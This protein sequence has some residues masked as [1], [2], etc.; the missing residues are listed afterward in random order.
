MQRIYCNQHLNFQKNYFVFKK[1]FDYTTG[2]EIWTG[3]WERH[4]IGPLT[5]KQAYDVCQWWEK[6]YGHGSTYS[7]TIQKL[8]RFIVEN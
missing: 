3:G 8:T 1:V 4:E 5:R 7:T 2:E 6:S